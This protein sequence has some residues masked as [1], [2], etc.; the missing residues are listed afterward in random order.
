L[1]KP[2]DIV[3][4]LC[5]LV[6]AHG[7]RDSKVR[8]LLFEAYQCSIH[9]N[10][11]QARDLLLLTSAQRLAD[12]SDIATQILYNRN[13][14]QLGLCAF[15]H[16]KIPGVLRV[17]DGHDNHHHVFVLAIQLDTVYLKAV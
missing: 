17:K 8:A 13:L 7:D 9:D 3:R 11:H 15:R 1:Q 16:G 12:A 14:V 10:Y 6:Y 5:E 4:N 2:S